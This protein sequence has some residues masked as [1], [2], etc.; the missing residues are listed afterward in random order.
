LNFPDALARILLREHR[1]PSLELLLDFLAAK[2]Y[3]PGSIDE[4]AVFGEKVGEFWRRFA[5]Q[6]EK[7]TASIALR[8][9]SLSG[10]NRDYRR[11]SLAHDSG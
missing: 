8:A 9:A 1:E 3:F 5:F 2:P 7:K 10:K 11:A 4:L 6:S